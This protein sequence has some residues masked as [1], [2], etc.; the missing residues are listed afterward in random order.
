MPT[1]PYKEFMA[2]LSFADVILDPFPF[3]GGVTTLDALAL[4]MYVLCKI[5]PCLSSITHGYIPN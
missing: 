3:G 2:L 1:L 5:S 4:G